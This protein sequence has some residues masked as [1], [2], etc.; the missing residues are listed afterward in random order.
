MFCVTIVLSNAFG[1]R[2]GLVAAVSTSVDVIFCYYSGIGA[3][4]S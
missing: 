4:H 3:R 2:V 1:D